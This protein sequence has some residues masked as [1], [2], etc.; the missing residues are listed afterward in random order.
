M[1]LTKAQEKMHPKKFESM[2]P[3]MAAYLS[4]LLGINSL[5]IASPQIISL[6]LMSDGFINTHTNA[7]GDFIES[8]EDLKGNF[9]EAV[10]EACNTSEGMTPTEIAEIY[11]LF[12]KHIDHRY[13]FMGGAG[14]E[15]QAKKEQT[16]KYWEAV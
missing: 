14:R 3:K 11:Q 8:Y 5:Q 6:G 15:A 1:K 16:T 12:Y 2:S 4:F 13:W 9:D 7:G 10:I